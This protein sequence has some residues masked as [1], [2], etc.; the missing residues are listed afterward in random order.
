[1]LW[2]ETLSNQLAGWLMQE[3]G[4][5]FNIENILSRY[6]NYHYN[7]RMVVGPS[8]LYDGNLYTV[9]Q[10]LY[11]EPVDWNCKRFIPV[12]FSVSPPYASYTHIGWNSAETYRANVSEAIKVPWCIM[13][14]MSVLVTWHDL[15]YLVKFIWKLNITTSQTLML[16]AL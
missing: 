7:D 9:R 12:P 14:A 5:G 1:M 4:I 10:H 13:D 15:K 3:T 16:I 11:V 6:R 8:Y 2:P